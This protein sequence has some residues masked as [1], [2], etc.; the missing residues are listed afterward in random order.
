MGLKELGLFIGFLFLVFL[1]LIM[2]SPEV[3]AAVACD[4][5][6]GVC[7]PGEA[8]IDGFCEPVENGNGCDPDTCSGLGYSC[9]TWD[10]SCGGTLNCGRCTGLNVCNSIGQ[11]VPRT[12]C[13][14]TCSSLGYNCGNWIICGVDTSCGSCTG[15]EICDTGGQCVE[16]LDSSDCTP[17]NSCVSGTCVSDITCSS[18]DQII[19]RLS[20]D[21]NAHGEVF[22]GAGDYPIEICFDDIFSAAGSGDRS[23][24]ENVK[25]LGLSDVTNAHAED[26]DQTNY[27]ID[28]CYSDII[29]CSV[30]TNDCGIDEPTEELIVSL[31]DNTNAHLA[32]DNSYPVKICCSSVISPEPCSLTAAYWDAPKVDGLF[33]VVEGTVVGLVVE[34]IGACNGKTVSFEVRE[35]EIWP[36]PNELANIQPIDVNF[37]GAT[38]RGTWTAEWFDDGF[39]QG[40]PEYF[41]EATITGDSINSGTTDANE[42][43][44]TEYDPDKP[45]CENIVIC[46]DY[47]GA[48]SCNIDDCNVSEYSVESQIGDNTF[49]DSSDINCFCSWD[50]VDNECDSGWEEVDGPSCG[51][52]IR[53]VGEVCDGTD[54]EGYS[55]TDFDEFA[56]GSLSCN[57]D[58]SGFITNQCTGY[59]CNNDSIRDVGEEACDGTDLGGYAC[60]DFDEFTGGILGCD[61]NCDFD[62]SSCTGD[63]DVPT[64]VGK[65]TYDEDTGGDTC[66]DGFLTFSW[67]AVWTWDPSC[68]ATCRAENQDTR[69]KCADGSRTIECPAQIPLPFF[70]AYNFIVALAIIALIY[71]LWSSNQGKKKSR[72][73]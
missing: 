66:D 46:S 58:C 3:Y 64:G 19:F 35:D 60:T 69:N 53:E 51:N 39:L 65:C 73:K 17:G 23:C 33:E 4:A 12:A 10:D 13:T 21:T 63:P 67:T 48:S 40:D 59:S 56:S 26:R 15:G 1:G 5:P 16:C 71:I 27:P 45:P 72:K 11:C 42:L 28:I 25:I 32:A 43:H 22:D 50:S 6:G 54:L 29:S 2:F 37:N 31:S 61:S 24:T 14:D 41:F 18:A 49:C 57:S 52:N 68:D 30:R 8:C 9:G 70:G 36:D 47:T 44:V 38:A 55:C 62:T 20:S 7:P 34:G